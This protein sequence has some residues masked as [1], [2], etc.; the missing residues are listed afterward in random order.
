MFTSCFNY[1]TNPAG[2]KQAAQYLHE[3]IEA[4][5]HLAQNKH[6]MLPIGFCIQNGEI[7]IQMLV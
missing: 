7:H 1:V 2:K 6:I 5:K 4:M 3:E